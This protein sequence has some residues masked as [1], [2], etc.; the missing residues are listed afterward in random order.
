M[1]VASHAIYKAK[2]K[3]KIVIRL[4]MSDITDLMQTSSGSTTFG[5]VSDH[6]VVLIL[7]LVGETLQMLPR[8]G[9]QNTR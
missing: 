2:N 6:M 1:P 3:L 8:G 5:D 9:F 4:D 7:I